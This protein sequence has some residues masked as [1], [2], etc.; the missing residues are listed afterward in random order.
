MT[1]ILFCQNRA[2]LQGTFVVACV[3]LSGS[4]RSGGRSDSRSVSRS[5]ASFH[6]PALKRLPAWEPEPKSRGRA[7]RSPRRAAGRR[8]GSPSSSP[9]P[10]PPPAAR[11]R[12][13]AD[14]SRR[15]GAFYSTLACSG[16]RACLRLNDT[17]RCLLALANETYPARRKTEI[18][19]LG[20][21]TRGWPLT[22]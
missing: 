7:A 16:W 2:A 6:S 13:S 5:G 22:L 8:R 15:V 21:L 3:S 1:A 12:R 10:S 4:L 14:T 18:I 19:H 17:K 11:S 9:S 20:A